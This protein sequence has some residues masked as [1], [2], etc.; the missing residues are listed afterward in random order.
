MRATRIQEVTMLTMNKTIGVLVIGLGLASSV[1]AGAGPR[2][3]ASGHEQVVDGGH[4]L[5]GHVSVGAGF[6]DPVLGAYDPYGPYPFAYYPHISYPLSRPPAAP[7]D[8]P[9]PPSAVLVLLDAHDAGASDHRPVRPDGQVV[10]SVIDG[11]R[12]YGPDIPGDT[13]ATVIITDPLQPSAAG[14]INQN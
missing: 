7:V 12:P 5:G 13:G 14:G 9:V 8:V 3:G 4:W 11:F 1:A 6:Y 10:T 2:R